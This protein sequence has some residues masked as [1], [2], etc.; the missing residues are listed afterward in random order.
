MS[1][2]SSLSSDSK[3]LTIMVEGRFDATCLDDFRRCYEEGGSDT[4]SKYIVDLQNTVHLD[5]SAL[6]MLLVLRDYAGGDQSNILI[7]NCSDDVKKI[8]A[9][10]A[11][12]QLFEIQ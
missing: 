9:I 12:S 7:D 10:S 11:F 4:V 1:I 6:G 5:S 8:F 2:E 3:T